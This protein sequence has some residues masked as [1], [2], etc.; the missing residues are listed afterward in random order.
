MT[1]A[2][3]NAEYVPTGFELVDLAPFV[4]G[5]DDAIDRIQQAEDWRRA[6]NAAIARQAKAWADFDEAAKAPEIVSLWEAFAAGAEKGAEGDYRLHAGRSIDMGHEFEKQLGNRRENHLPLAYWPKFV[7]HLKEMA[8]LSK[9]P[10]ATRGGYG[11]AAK[12]ISRIEGPQAL[13]RA[14]R[15]MDRLRNEGHDVSIW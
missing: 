15:I 6:C 12:M 11:I 14:M 8:R 13:L 2:N 9:T 4:D 10:D 1:A 3:A 7:S 5:D